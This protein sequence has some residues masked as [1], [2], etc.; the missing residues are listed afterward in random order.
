M[1]TY[2]ISVHSNF[3]FNWQ[4]SEK[5]DGYLLADVKYKWNY[6][7]AYKT[8]KLGVAIPCFSPFDFCIKWKHEK[9]KKHENFKSKNAKGN[10]FTFSSLAFCHFVIFVF[11]LVFSLCKN[12]K[13]EMKK[14]RKWLLVA[15]IPKRTKSTTIV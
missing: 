15:S 9:A 6:Y 12:K 10:Y 8:W 1:C 4:L 2:M 14:T 13:I 5:E 7:V 11:A 3:I